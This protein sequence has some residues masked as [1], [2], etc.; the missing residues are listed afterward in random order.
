MADEPIADSP[1]PAAAVVHPGPMAALETRLAALEADR[2]TVKGELAA[3]ARRVLDLEDRRKV[4]VAARVTDTARDS[5]MAQATAFLAE[6]TSAVTKPAEGYFIN[7]LFAWF[8]CFCIE[9]EEYV[10][11]GIIFAKLLRKAGVQV[12]RGVID[13]DGERMDGQIAFVEVSQ[14]FRVAHAEWH[15]KV[16]PGVEH[17]GAAKM[18]DTQTKAN[19]IIAARRNAK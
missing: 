1:Q 4:K 19:Q 11:S 5:A 6:H 9:R 7:E 16:L 10:P 3:L 8:A 13:N 12:R 18:T 2:L 17:Y 15:S 14:A